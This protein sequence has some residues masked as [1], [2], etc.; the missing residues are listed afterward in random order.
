MPIKRW[1]DAGTSL[2]RLM[3]ILASSNFGGYTGYTKP[4]NKFLNRQFWFLANGWHNSAHSAVDP[5]IQIALRN[6][7]G[8]YKWSPGT[9][10]WQLLTTESNRDTYFEKYLRWYCVDGHLD[11]HP[12]GVD[13]R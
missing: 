6:G 5:D 4:F 8:T 7:V 1:A 13:A 2:L 11:A 3:P 9:G 10:V 12:D